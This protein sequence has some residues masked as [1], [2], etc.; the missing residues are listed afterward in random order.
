MLASMGQGDKQDDSSGLTPAEQLAQLQAPRPI[1]ITIQPETAVAIITGAAR[2]GG[3]G[4]VFH[5]PKGVWGEGGG[6]GDAHGQQ[7]MRRPEQCSCQ[8][9]A[10]A[11]TPYSHKQQWSSSQVGVLCKSPTGRWYVEGRGEGVLC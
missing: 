3:E 7:A 5:G 11:T 9:T 6:G 4:G 10:N 1:D 8:G 2:G